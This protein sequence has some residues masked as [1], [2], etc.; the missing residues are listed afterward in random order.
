MLENEAKGDGKK[1][2]GHWTALIA[3]THFS[4]RRKNWQEKISQAH[5]LQQ[6]RLKNYNLLYNSE[7]DHR[8]VEKF[9]ALDNESEQLLKQAITAFQLSARSYHKILKISRRWMK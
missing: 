3:L 1:I 7:M 5:K 4:D 8:Q 6:A 9:C 2:R